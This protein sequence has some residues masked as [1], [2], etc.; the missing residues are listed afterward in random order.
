MKHVVEPKKIDTPR[1]EPIVLGRNY[2][3]KPAS[4]HDSRSG[5]YWEA[6]PEMGTE[7][8]KV[9]PAICPGLTK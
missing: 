9:L 3:G 4:F 7:A 2:T 5:V 6:L 8:R 1:R